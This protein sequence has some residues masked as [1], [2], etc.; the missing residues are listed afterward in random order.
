MVVKGIGKGID[1]KVR[2]D[3]VRSQVSEIGA[4]AVY[5]FCSRIQDKWSEERQPTILRD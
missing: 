5:G 3:V 4:G 1:M 2:I